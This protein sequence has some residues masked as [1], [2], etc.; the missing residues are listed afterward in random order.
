METTPK[1]TLSALSLAEM[2]SVAQ[3]V[4]LARERE[5][6]CS[7]EQLQR[8]NMAMGY[9]LIKLFEAIP[10]ISK[11]SVVKLVGAKGISHI[12]LGDKD[13]SKRENAKISYDMKKVFEYV[14]KIKT[15]ELF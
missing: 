5:E 8:R 15:T 1:N 10:T 14:T 4:A 12:T 6:G 11:N 2:L 7:P 9:F 13:M 3:R